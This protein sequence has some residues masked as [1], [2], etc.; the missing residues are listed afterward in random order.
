MGGVNRGD[1]YRKKSGGF[2]RKS[3]FKK[4]HKK[5]ALAVNDFMLLNAWGAWCQIRLVNEDFA[6]KMQPLT[7]AEFIAV[8]AEELC[9]YYDEHERASYTLIPRLKKEHELAIATKVNYE[10]T[11]VKIDRQEFGRM[12]SCVVCR[13]ETNWNNFRDEY[14]CGPK[15]Q[16]GLVQ[17]KICKIIAHCIPP[18]CERKIFTY[19][20]QGMTC[21][22]IAHQDT[23][24]CIF[25]WK[26][27]IFFP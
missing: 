18:K 12:P 11:F 8:Y 9:E 16:T 15:S 5:A 20:R 4:W 1:F 3:H 7:H 27:V 17:C 14:G 24:L 19:F 2:A 13:I 6:M 22:E 25:T 26:K 23:N 21:F 10:H